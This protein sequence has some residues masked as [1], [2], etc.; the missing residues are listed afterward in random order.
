MVQRKKL[1]TKDLAVVFGTFAPMHI[2][3]LSMILRAKKKH[4]GV[5]VVTSGYDGDRGEDVDL[6]LHKRFRYVRELFTDDD[7]V[8][9]GK[10]DETKMPRYPDGWQ[11]WLAELTNVIQEAISYDVSEAN[12]TIYCGESEYKDTINKLQPEW[13]V[14][15]IDR[16]KIVDVSATAIRNNPVQYFKYITRPFKKH[17]TKKVL[18]AGPASTGK[19]TLATDLGKLFNA[20]VSLEYAREY[21]DKY[22]VAD[23]ELDIKDYMYLL[24][25]QYEQTSNLI[26]GNSNNGLIIADTN[27]IV[28]VAYIDYYLKDMISTKDYEMLHK[29]YLQILHKERWDLIL[30]T[31]P[32]ADYI[33]DGFRDMTMQDEDIRQPLTEHLLKLFKEAGLQDKVRLLDHGS[34]K[35]MYL[36][37]LE[38][39]IRLIEDEIGMKLGTL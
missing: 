3:H 1:M 23:D 4:D 9:V 28:T 20:P 24:T 10:L 35:E 17:F 39:S 29:M 16:T 27:S 38:E 13:S 5:V 14:E 33:D 21:Q 26:D 7:F 2:G 12:I 37:N 19:T 18:L 36:Y 11:P 25:G 6:P 34:D 22:N 31:T 32:N 8:N 15:L 30:V